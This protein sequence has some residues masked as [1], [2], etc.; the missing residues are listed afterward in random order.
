MGDTLLMCSQDRENRIEWPK[1]FVKVWVWWYYQVEDSLGEWKIF[2]MGSKSCFIFTIMTIKSVGTIKGKWIVHT[3]KD[4]T[5]FFFGKISC[6]CQVNM[7]FYSEYNGY[8]ILD[9]PFDNLQLDFVI[10]FLKC[11]IQSSFVKNQ[12]NFLRE[13]LLKIEL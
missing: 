4:Y 5:E 9:I 3:F 12:F 1:K 7:K 8:W 13:A 11:G 2:C 6:L 10:C